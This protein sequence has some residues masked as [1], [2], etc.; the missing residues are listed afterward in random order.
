MPH[1]AADRNLLFG[2][3]ALQMDFISK[4]ALIA[5]MNAW[6]LDK[7]R[8]LGQILAEQGALLA[9]NREL[10]E[11]LVSRHV[12]THGNDAQRSLAALGPVRHDL[13]QI[14]DADV[15]ASLAHV[16][17]TPTGPAAEATGPYVPPATLPPHARFQ[18]LRPHAKG[19]LGEVYVARDEEL[20]REVALKEIQERHAH[21][22]ESRA[23]FLL[24]AEITGG[25]EHPGIVPVYGLGTYSDGRPFYAMR[26][27]KGESL[28]DAI[29]RFYRERESLAAGECTLRLRQ[30]LGRF[31][32]VCNAVAYAHSRGVLHRDLKPSNVMLGPYGET[33]VVDWGLAKALDQ[34]GE[35]ATEGPLRAT[36]SSDAELTQAGTALGTP[37]YMSP[38]Q[39]AGRQEQLG[40]R[41]DVYSLGATLYCLLTGQAPFAESDAGALLGKVQRGDFAAPRQVSRQVPPALEA[42]CLKAM[43]LQPADRYATPRE[44]AEELERWLAD[45]PV[46]AY[47]EPLPA[48]LGRW[49]RRHQKL[50]VG[51]GVLLLTGLAALGVS[52]LLVGDALRRAEQARKE[53]ALAQVDAL[54]SAD[55]KAVPA[56]L[57]GLEATP[58]D[59]LPRLRELWA[60]EDRPQR[61]TRR[62]RV[63]LALLTVE[64]GLVKD[65]L[66]TWMLEADD[67]REV[68]LVREALWPYRAELREWL[69]QRTNLLLHVLDLYINEKDRPKERFRALVALAAYD[70]GDKRWEQDGELV[71]EE[72]LTANP[73]YLGTWADAL[74]P[75]RRALLKPLAEVFRGKKLAEH[76]HVAA[77][78]LADYAADQ[79]PLLVDLALDGDARQYAALLPALKAQAQKARPRLRAELA[80]PAPEKATDAARDAVAFRQAN[81]ALTLLHLGEPGPVWSLLVHSADPS[82]RTYLTHHLAPYGVSAALLLKRLEVETDASAR[83]ALLLSLGEYRPEQVWP[84]H[85]KELSFPILEIPPDLPKGPVTAYVTPH[86]PGKRPPPRDFVARLVKD[87]RDDPDPG[88]HAAIEWLLR[89]WGEDGELPK[90]RNHRP[91]NAPKGKPTWYVNGQG[92]TLTVIPG[93]LKFQ[94]GSPES[95]PDRALQ[96]RLH[97]RKIPRSFAVGTKEVT[98]ADFQRFLKARP[99]LKRR[100]DPNLVQTLKKRSPDADGPMIMVNWHIAAEYCNWLSKEEGLPQRE[101]CYPEDPAEF[102][103]PLPKDHLHRKGYR[104][105]TEAEWEYACRAGAA[106]SRYYGRSPALLEKYAWYR[107]NAGERAHP[108]GRL[109]PND[110]GLLDMLGNVAEWC[111]DGYALYP[112]GEAVEDTEEIIKSALEHPIR[113]LRGGS[114]SNLEESLRCALRHASPLTI[115]HSNAGLRVARTID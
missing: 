54:L 35:P 107:P 27:V 106:T 63:G 85:R 39:A 47:R 20:R 70:P 5:A 98:V 24:E 14:A 8:P 42:V 38:E 72:L 104:L 102:I 110:L 34:A 12:E 37:A 9:A 3:L 46:R 32:A 88:I 82:R 113:V 15:Q 84:G 23:R 41:S 95:E 67:P 81:A 45:E 18:I 13:G 58:D 51:A 111:Q 92:Q 108:G 114:I 56:L 68:L 57:A 36:L 71:L 17:S 99:E 78:L 31:V 64:P 115:G 6:A 109:R 26:L 48:R 29:A 28:K 93:P 101:W 10:L 79:L 4:D 61:R 30:L 65:W 50:T 80:K 66:C 1:P 16:V 76:K 86:D 7:A 40:P 73:L 77:S 100:L 33:L 21:S 22:P 60:E 25:L 90:L 89:R 52:T 19:G 59:V 96:E 94:M 74:R 103:K 87:Y 44:L 53:R 97:E 55:P 49:A 75:V 69:W 2:I 105:P 112:P 43:A 11:V 91:K 62:G 83:R